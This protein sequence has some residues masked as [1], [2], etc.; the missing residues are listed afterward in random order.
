VSKV[1]DTAPHPAAAALLGVAAC[2]REQEHHSQEGSPEG[3]GVRLSHLTRGA[4]GVGV[5]LSHPGAQGA[6]ARVHV[7]T[8]RRMEGG[9][10]I[11]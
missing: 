7:Q 6:R 11:K 9:H 5:R 8:S 2:A 1:C 3:V 10:D 4:Q